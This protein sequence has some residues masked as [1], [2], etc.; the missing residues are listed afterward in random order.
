MSDLNSAE[1][2]ADANFG[3]DGVESVVQPCSQDAPT[4][5][6][7][8]KTHWIEIAL[9]D[10]KHNPVPGEAYI[11]KLPNGSKV[12]GNLDSRGNAR[13][14]GIDPGTCQITFP[15]LDEGGWH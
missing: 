6:S 1:N 14:D 11:V 12:S 8:Q 3:Y 4:V 2:D 10:E 9:V 7:P 5:V 15:E 13:I